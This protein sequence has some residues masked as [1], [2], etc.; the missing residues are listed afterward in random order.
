MTRIFIKQKYLN[1]TLEGKKPLEGRVGYNNIKRLK[2]G[3]YIYLNGQHKAQIVGIK[4]YHTFKDAVDESNFRLLIPDTH[5]VEEA[6]KIYEKLYPIWKQRK[7]G[8]YI[9]RI[10]YPVEVI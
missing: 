5:S 9:F 7:F 4:K 2:V 3:D 8:V 1:Y 6:I 10:K